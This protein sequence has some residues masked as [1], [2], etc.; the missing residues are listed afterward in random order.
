MRPSH[1]LPLPPFAPGAHVVVLEA[2]AG[3]ERRERL[4]AWVRACAGQ[5]GWN[6]WLLPCDTSRGGLWAGVDTWLQALLP[7]LEP[8]APALFRRHDQ[9]ITQV[10]PL[11]LRRIR[12]RY[13]PLTESSVA[14][15]AVRNYAADRA[16]RIGHGVIDLLA[17][18]HAESGAGRWAL[19]CEAFDRRGAIAGHFFQ[20][21]LRRRGHALGLVLVAAVDPGHGDAVEAELA[22]H[23]R[24]TRVRIELEPSPE[25]Q[26]DPAEAAR[27]AEEMD[28]WVREDTV[29]IRAHGHEVIRLWNAAGR[30]DRAADWHAV[31]MGL[32]TQMGFYADALRHAA[33]VRANLALFDRPGFFFTRTALVDKLQ[34]I[35]LTAGQPEVSREILQTEGL[36]RLTDPADRVRVLYQMAMLHGRHLPKRDP[37]AAERY[38]DEAMRELE[39]AE[40]KPEERA[41]LTAFLLNGL[42]YL[43]F[44]QGNA[45]EAIELSHGNSERLDRS[46][47]P[48]RHRLHRSVL[49]YNAGQVYAQAGAVDEAIRHYEMAM[50][51]D[52]DYSEYYNDRGNLYLK[53]GRAAEAEQDFRRAI[54]LSPPYPEVW[55][56]LGQ[57]LAR[58]GRGAEAEAAWERAVDL[59]PA[60]PEP[61]AGLARA[62][63]ARGERDEALR[64]YDAAVAADPANA[65]LRANRAAVRFEAGR[66]HEAME[67]LDRAVELA[68]DNAALRRNRALAQEAVARRAGAALQPA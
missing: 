55:F 64:A 8:E 58:Q 9:E 20:H 16:Y 37:A 12:P 32:L 17:G 51:M 18:W 28:A 68:P 47:P 33:V 15:E 3:T 56:N 21:L 43:R 48:G 39:R 5:E 24:V 41:F 25:A 66:L 65:L 57:A 11:L 45:G 62:R 10:L 42:A 14:E 53:Q 52:P 1:A 50:E 49:L 4:E 67:D 7:R 46:L 22:P 63:H 35:H 59:D 54:E 29:Y 2:E 44:R 30:P 60:R 31:V 40:M 36:D 26:P 23:A 38:L 27:L 6:A 19:A 34:V 13:V 61:W